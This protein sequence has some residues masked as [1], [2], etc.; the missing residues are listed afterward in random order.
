MKT[1]KRGTK[2][3]L[4]KPDCFKKNIDRKA[5]TSF[6]TYRDVS[7]GNGTAGGEKLIVQVAFFE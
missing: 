7:V 3:V 2:N 5:K 6:V 4:K 1:K